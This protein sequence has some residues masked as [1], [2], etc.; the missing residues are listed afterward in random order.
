MSVK[1]RPVSVGELFA[2]LYKGMSLDPNTQI[3]D[4]LGRPTGLAGDNIKPI[5]ELV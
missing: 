5:D 1:D 2:T 3:R 4:N